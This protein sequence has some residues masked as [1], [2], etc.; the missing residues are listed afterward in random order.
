MKTKTAVILVLPLAVIMIALPG[1]ASVQEHWTVPGGPAIPES[2]TPDAEEKE[3][4]EAVS[5]DAGEWEDARRQEEAR[6]QREATLREIE[7]QEKARREEEARLQRDAL[8]REAEAR[9]LARWQEELRLERETG[10]AARREI[11]ARELARRQEE[12]RQED[13]EEAARKEEEGRRLL[14]SLA[15]RGQAEYPPGE[16]AIIPLPRYYIVQ[17]GDTFNRIAADPRIYNNSSEW[18]VLYQA[19]RD[20]LRDPDNPDQLGAGMVIEI[21]SIAGEN[22]EGT[23]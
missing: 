4:E 5:G 17:A 1:C 18:F 6:L 22:R 3:D 19:N 7:A 15:A 20:K 9:E 11:E 12:S 14:E 8:R 23:Y 10:E 16:T 2:Q 21:P 13:A